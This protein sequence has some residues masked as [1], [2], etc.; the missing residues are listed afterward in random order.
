LLADLDRH[1]GRLNVLAKA[2]EITQ[3][4][5][6][7]HGD[8]DKTVPLRHAEELKAAQPNAGFVII[9]GTDHSFGGYHPYGTDVLPP[10]LLAFCGQV[11]DFLRK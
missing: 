7:V 2:T 6:I 4:W 9:P 10:P 5:L 8:E 3:P 1:P 11:I